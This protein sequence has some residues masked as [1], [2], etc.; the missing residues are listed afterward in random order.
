MPTQKKRKRKRNGDTFIKKNE[1]FD[2]Q[3]AEQLNKVRDEV[4]AERERLLNEARTQAD[5]MSAKRQELLKKEAQNL[6]KDISLRTQH[7]VFAIARK[8]LADLGTASLEKRLCEVFVLRLRGLKG[9]AKEDIANALKTAEEPTLLR[10]A[11]DLPTEQ[12][13]IIQSAINETFEDDIHLVFVTASDLIGGIE[14]TANGYKIAWNIANYLVSM[15]NGLDE[16]LPKKDE[17]K[18]RSKDTAAAEKSQ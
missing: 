15:E 8:T 6:D 18:T 12:R 14:L 1:D 16:I 5:D 17:T 9:K 4:K 7:E 10:T 2:R 3:H 11:F 13:D